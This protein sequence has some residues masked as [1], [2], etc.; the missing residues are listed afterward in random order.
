VEFQGHVPTHFANWKTLGSPS[1]TPPSQIAS[2]G[3][4]LLEKYGW[5][6]RGCLCLRAVGGGMAGETRAG[7]QA[8]NN[9]FATTAQVMQYQPTPPPNPKTSYESSSATFASDELEL[10]NLPCDL[11]CGPCRDAPEM[12]ATAFRKRSCSKVFKPTMEDKSA[13]DASTSAAN[14]TPRSSAAITRLSSRC[15]RRDASQ[16]RRRNSFH[17][18]SGR[19]VQLYTLRHRLMR[20]GSHWGQNTCCPNENRRCWAQLIDLL[21]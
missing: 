19:D 16:T 12:E 20:T 13:A 5:V 17:A 15:P 7:R 14:A 4:R 2:C 21:C 8:W 3:L 6:V 10:E 9:F 18:K 11:D 1:T